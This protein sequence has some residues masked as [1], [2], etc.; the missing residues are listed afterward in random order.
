MGNTLL[1]AEKILRH[2]IQQKMDKD[3]FVLI[4]QRASGSQL[5]V[6]HTIFCST[7]DNQA[8]EGFSRSLLSSS[9]NVVAVVDR[10]ADISAAA[11][12]VIRARISFNGRSS[13]APDVVLVNEFAMKEFCEASIK[14]LTKNLSDGN[15]SASPRLSSKGYVQKPSPDFDAKTLIST[16]RGSIEIIPNR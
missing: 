8:P 12:T 9:S 13:Y 6:A 1:A 2:I 7:D 5:S 16:D 10:S 3:T 11:E 15:G 14:A 4:D